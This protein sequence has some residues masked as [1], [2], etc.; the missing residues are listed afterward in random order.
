M[1]AAAPAI[2]AIA[3]S[4]FGG[5]VASAALAGT[6]IGASGF[7]VGMAVGRAVGSMVGS[8]L[9][10]SLFGEKPRLP[11]Y[12]T[13]LEDRGLLQ[14]VTGANEPIQVI[15]GLRRVGGVRVFAETSGTDNKYLHLVNVLGE[16]EIDQ[17][18]QIYLNETEI[19][20]SK[21]SGE[22]ATSEMSNVEV[23]KQVFRFRGNVDHILYIKVGCAESGA[24]TYS[25]SGSSGTLESGAAAAGITY[26]ESP[27]GYEGEGW[28]GD[29]SATIDLTP[30][31]SALVNASKI[32]DATL[33]VAS[34]RGGSTISIV[35]QPTTSNNYE[36][37]IKIY[38]PNGGEGYFD[39]SLTFREGSNAYADHFGGEFAEAWVH[40]GADDQ[41][42]DE[43]L[44]NAISAW[45]SSHTL[46][47]VAYLYTRLKYDQDVFAGGI[48]VITADVKGVKVYDPRSATTAWSDNPA[49]C[50]RDY[51]TN[52]RYGRAIPASMIDEASFIAAANY[53]DETVTKGGSSA[54]RYT[55]NGVVDTG[56]TSLE[57]IREMLT[58]CRGMLVFT[59]GVY[60]LLIDKPETAAFAFT[61]DNIIGAWSISLGDKTNTYNRVQANFFN[62]ARAWQ[63]DIATIDSTTLRT[64]D[65]GLLLEREITLPFTSDEATAKQIATINLNQSRQQILTEFTATIAG[66]RCEVGDVVTITHTTPGWSAKKFRIL[67]MAL[68]NND[69]VRVTAL[70]YDE[71]VY[72][73]G[74]IATSDATPN[75]NLPSL[76]SVVAP[77]NLSYAESLYFNA[78]TLHNRV[79]LNWEASEDAFVYKYEVQSQAYNSSGSAA[80]GPWIAR[81]ETLSSTFNIDD[82]DV[83]YYAFRV[84]AVN[85]INVRSAWLTIGAQAVLGDGVLPAVDVPAVSGVSESL[86]Y[87]TRGSGVKAKA[88]LSWGAST[89]NTQWEAI[90]V[91]ID[92][93]ECESKLSS[94]STWTRAGTTDGVQFEFLDQQPGTW[95]FRVR[96]VNDAGVASAWSSVRQVIYGLTARPADLTGLALQI[97]NGQAH[98]SWSPST[99]LDVK[100]GGTIRFRYSTLTSGAEW[101]NAIDI[102]EQVP[103]AANGTVLPLL[104]G[105]YMAK[106]VDSTGNESENAAAVVTTVPSLLNLNLVSTDAQQPGFS[107]S[108]TNMIVDST[109]TP[110]VLKLAPTV[111]WDSI[112]D[113]MDDWGLIDAVGG[114][115]PA[116]SYA[117]DDYIDLGFKQTWRVTPTVA[118]TV[119][120][121]ADTID[122]R[123][124]YLDSWKDWDD[125]G[126]DMTDVVATLYVATTDDDPAG[127][128]TW[129]SWKK[130]VVGDYEARA[131]KFK[132]EVAI[133]DTSHQIYISTLEVEVDAP[134]RT[135]WVKGNT[136]TSGVFSV[137][138]TNRFYVEPSLAITAQN[139][140]SGDYYTISNESETGFD[141][142]FFDSGNSGISRTFN[143]FARGY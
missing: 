97:I 125:N 63:P 73:F 12:S 61:E 3:G 21:F 50:I 76:T 9:A 139:M 90:N 54:K 52:A 140:T 23:T 111:A 75:T 117:F 56:R 113:A 13:P 108:K 40:T 24:P 14:N 2:G 110:P 115:S 99:D 39:F 120:D 32:H 6:M 94:A 101:K 96:A 122:Q 44:V 1:P 4:Y 87:S 26:D 92:R 51:L 109:A 84:R 37:I 100:V 123:T 18:Q 67:R 20:D 137:T 47:G 134:D 119:G 118:F 33:S 38:E 16:G 60:R 142:Q 138:Y 74:T 86:Y 70:E 34:K 141:I 106:A 42:A 77:I 107:G 30:Y 46:S 25:G 48:P 64:Q 29:L 66:L 102:G 91:Y 126:K 116:G 124:A 69:E 72:D 27:S 121:T 81:G 53:C 49:L 19:S 129:S 88:T 55:L 136:T 57:V 22:A 17:V 83:G 62:P 78:P 58:A 98:F 127:S 80:A 65:N 131:F 95:D 43:E 93:Y 85:T 68:Q 104:S 36:A 135:E 45:T 143:Y 133:S 71:T 5:Y 31:N 35:Q 128:P 59:G 105:T 28:H 8:S 15:Y 7:I 89:N 130:I 103:G 11:D 114:L 112:P 79:T 132:I 41:A 82:L 10:T